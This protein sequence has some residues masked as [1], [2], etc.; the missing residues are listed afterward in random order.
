VPAAEVLAWH[1]RDSAFERLTP[2]WAGVTVIESRGTMEPGDG[3]RLKIKFGP[4]NTEWRIIHEALPGEI[5]FLDRQVSGP[6][7]AWT[8]EHRFEDDPNGGSWLEDRITLKLP[9]GSAGNRLAGDRVM[10]TVNRNFAFRHQQ[11]RHDL[12]LHA[13]Y[14]DRKPMRIAVTG[15]TGLIGRRL[16]PFLKS[17]GHT[18]L[19]IVRKPT[20]APGEIT[21]NPDRGEIDAK[22][23]EG[24]DAVIHLA[25]ESIA[26]GRWNPG[27]KERIRSSRTKGTALLARTIAS[28]E[29][30]PRV[31]VS[32]SGIGFYGNRGDELLTEA[33][34]TGEGFLA[35]VCRVWEAAADPARAA[36][37][38]VVHPRFGVVLAS[39]GG[40]L[41]QLAL[42]FK[43][44]LGG[45]IG[46]GKQYVSWIAIDDLLGVLLEAVMN[47]NLEGPVN[48]VAPGVV[49]NAEFTKALGRAF[50]RPTIVPI[51]AFAIKAAFGE[52]A[53]ELLLVSQRSVPARLNDEQFPYTYPTIDAALRHELTPENDPAVSR[54]E[55][56]G[57]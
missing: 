38:R 31:F 16:L 34:T 4:L 47:E 28:L 21:W 49:T 13:R 6:F 46:S 2:P 56:S 35:E 15:S 55:R 20:G 23:L 19:P 44:G 3:K 43:L 8:H 41:K 32:T 10:H 25:G 52:M 11:T 54:T 45:R 30:K 18:V 26:G 1:G 24:C 17:G 27:R 7:A 48:V 39:E 29:Q 33:S 37:I 51:P 40:M 9:L 42:P 36:G 12:T 22:A 5:G 57:S 50:R 14:A 53:D